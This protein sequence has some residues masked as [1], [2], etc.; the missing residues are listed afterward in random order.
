MNGLDFMGVALLIGTGFAWG[1]ISGR[2]RGY[3]VGHADGLR[4]GKIIQG[5]VI[6]K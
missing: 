3:R 6:S 1:F 2:G 4:R 5:A